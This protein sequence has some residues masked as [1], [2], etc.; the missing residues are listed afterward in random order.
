[1]SVQS[2]EVTV[3]DLVSAPA[4]ETTSLSATGAVSIVSEMSTSSS[5]VD[6]ASDLVTDT[7]PVVVGPR[8]P[9]GIAEAYQH[10]QL[11]AQT[12]WTI[13][14]M[15]G[16]DPVAIQVLIDGT[17]HDEWTTIFTV[18]GVCVTLGFDVSVAGIARMI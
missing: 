11:V 3:V 12:T 15:L 7:T 9:G 1:M 5:A 2:P 6:L 14:H 4:L 17:P 10:V 8:G 18:P 16:H 13:Y